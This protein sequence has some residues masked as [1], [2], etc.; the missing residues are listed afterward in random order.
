MGTPSPKKTTQ[1]RQARRNGG[2]EIGR[3]GV[4]EER[5]QPNNRGQS[6]IMHKSLPCKALNTVFIKNHNFLENSFKNLLTI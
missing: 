3:S 6:R 5:R 2:Q 1:G 4:S